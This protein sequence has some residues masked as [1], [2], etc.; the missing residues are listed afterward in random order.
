MRYHPLRRTLYGGGILN[1]NLYIV[2]F[3]LLIQ[4]IAIIVLYDKVKNTA[5][6][7]GEKGEKGE[8]G[9]QGI[10]GQQGPPG[11]AGIQGPQG[12][13]GA[14]GSKG[15][16]GRQGP[17]GPVCTDCL[18]KGVDL[19]DNQLNAL[20]QFSF[21]GNTVKVPRLESTSRLTFKELKG[22]SDAQVVT[23]IQDEGPWMETDD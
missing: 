7:K 11:A 5:G 21:S 10:Q 9:V 15:A 1:L 20:K 13:P 23:R 4:T 2:G 18:R 12:A 17:E 6:P 8:K 3:I 14:V 19:S 22:A 16:A